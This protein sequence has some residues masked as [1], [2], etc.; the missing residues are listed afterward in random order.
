M[1]LW[2]HYRPPEFSWHPQYVICKPRD[3]YRC[4]INCSL[5]YSSTVKGKNC[6]HWQTWEGHFK[7]LFVCLGLKG[8]SVW[9]G[10]QTNCTKTRAFLFF[11][12]Q[13]VT[14]ILQPHLTHFTFYILDLYSSS[15]TCCSLR[16]IVKT[17]T[18]Y[19]LLTSSDDVKYGYH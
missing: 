14:K 1:E 15:L 18:V 4:N 2:G 10:I 3:F 13:T 8:K 5:L 16:D 9:K 19:V 6:L 12:R 7:S 11:K 17:L